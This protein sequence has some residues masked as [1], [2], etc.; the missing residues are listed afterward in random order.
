M[1]ENARHNVDGENRHLDDL[2][3]SLFK[4]G[5]GV[6]VAALLVAAGAGIALMGL[7]GFLHAYLINFAF[8]LTLVLGGLFFVV[9][10]HL[11]RAGWSV[12]VRRV[13]ELVSANA[14]LMAILFV[15]ILLSVFVGETGLDQSKLRASWDPMSAEQK[16]T[17][18]NNFETYRKKQ[19]DAANAERFVLYPWASEAYRKKF[20]L[21]QDKTAYLDPE[22]FAVRW[23]IFLGLWV[24]MALYFLRGS[25]RQDKSGDPEI[26]TRMQLWSAPAMILLAFTL[27]FGAFD[28]LMSLQPTWFSTI[29][30]V[31]IFAGSLVGFLAIAILLFM[32]LQKSGR[33]VNAVTVEHYHDLGKLLFAFVVFWGYVSFSQFMLI[34]YGNIP[35]ETHW[36]T[37]RKDGVWW[38]VSIVGLVFG[39]LIFPLLGLLSRHV[40][41]SRVMLAFWC[42]WLLAA[43][44]IDLCWNIMPGRTDTVYG[45]TV[46]GAAGFAFVCAACFVGMGGLF[47]AGVARAGGQNSLVPEKDPRLGESLAFENL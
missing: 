3:D 17:H 26:T 24:G 4:K 12:V 37:L 45:D 1:A 34:W 40:K 2:A 8:F 44:W 22:F 43:H 39:H 20:P 28:L 36:F 13:A 14:I 33:L 18:D 21:V 15:P 35:E 29:Y 10:Q 25:V 38:Y 31:Y 47:V 16:A 6:G 7:R 11:V 46:L 27:T 32:L 23:V 30:G 41:R 42:V 9:L 19:E 5:I